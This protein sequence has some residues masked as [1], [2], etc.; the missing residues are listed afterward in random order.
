[1]SAPLAVRTVLASLPLVGVLNK[2]TDT[3]KV[4]RCAQK[5][6]EIPFWQVALLEINWK[7][8]KFD[9]YFFI[10]K[11]ALYINS[12]ITDNNIRQSKIVKIYIIV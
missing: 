5:D 9:R 7:S 10:F 8:S 11:I 3:H 2:Y 6:D 12:I 1:M 4:R